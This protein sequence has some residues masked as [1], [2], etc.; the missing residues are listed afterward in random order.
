MGLVTCLSKMLQWAEVV[1]AP[2]S[3][4]FVLMVARVG[5]WLK[6]RGEGN[7]GGLLS[8]VE[9][10]QYLAAS[11]LK[12]PAANE[13]NRKRVQ[14][15]KELCN[16]N[17][18]TKVDIEKY[19][20]LF[21]STHPR[22]PAEIWV[23]RKLE[24]RM[25][26][27]YWFSID[28]TNPLRTGIWI[29]G[30]GEIW[31]SIESWYQVFSWPTYVFVSQE[32]KDHCN[33]IKIAVDKFGLDTKM[34][35]WAYFWFSWFKSTQYYIDAIPERCRWSNIIAIQVLLQP[36]KKKMFTQQYTFFLD[37]IDD[38]VNRV[39]PETGFYPFTLAAVDN[40]NL[41]EVLLLV[42]GVSLARVKIC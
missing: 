8:C 41:T 17:K 11:L 25:L 20:L 40:N 24:S 35:R 27:T 13:Y 30:R 6:V 38:Q 15:L 2:V 36:A 10:I 5:C 29:W 16:L 42:I 21:Y 12:V 39:D 33:A 37:P 32:S 7:W 3:I 23:L 19:S 18:L 4:S 26:E 1:L 34:C 9:P 31:N 28:S 14:V 22:M